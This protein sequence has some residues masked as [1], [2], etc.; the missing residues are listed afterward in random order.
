MDNKTFIDL[1]NEYDGFELVI[2]FRDDV[3]HYIGGKDNKVWYQV[4]KGS[5]SEYYVGTLENGVWTD[6][7]YKAKKHKVVSSETV[8]SG[9][10]ISK[11]EERA[12]FYRDKI[13][14][15]KPQRVEKE[16]DTY[17][18]YVFGFGERAWE[19]SEKYGVTTFFSD[20]NK[21]DEG[22]H[23]RDIVIGSDVEKPSES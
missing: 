21:E 15:K 23:L 1:V 3:D 8:E 13:G 6:K 11:V 7:F 14:T 10:T 18:H 19:V 17:L 16:E 12:F 20:I 22:Y 5:N 2:G 9:T 4:T